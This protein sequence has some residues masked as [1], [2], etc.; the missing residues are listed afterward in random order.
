MS[1][2]SFVMSNDDLDKM[3]ER[4][5]QTLQNVKELQSMEEQLYSQL[6]NGN[7][8][9][10]EDEENQ[11]INKINEL[12]QMRTGLFNSMK[13][14]Y[15]FLQNNVAESRDDLVNQL[16]TLSV[17]ESQL[18]TAKENLK[19]LKREKYDQLR[20]VEINT[21]FGDQYR[22]KGQVMRLLAIFCVPILLIVLITNSNIIPQTILSTQTQHSISSGLIF[23]LI[24]LAIYYIGKKLWDI[25]NRDNMNFSEYQWNFDPDSINPTVYDYDMNQ[26]SS[27][28]NTAKEYSQNAY[29]K[30]SKKL[31]GKGNN[32]VG[33]ACCAKGT[34]WS[35]KQNKCLISSNEAAVTNKLTKGAMSEPFTIDMNST[36]Q[37]ILPYSPSENQYVAV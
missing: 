27:G 22:A 3:Q 4:H 16:T 13:D 19:S 20:M 11:I 36:N 14:M 31:G 15:L 34:T 29:D 9:L 32:C 33:Q 21:Y 10:S 6:E 7:K 26:L 37:I 1:S 8:N 2:A 5:S 24:L 23:V 30:V 25:S 18:N 28:Y 12:S 17:V 35:P